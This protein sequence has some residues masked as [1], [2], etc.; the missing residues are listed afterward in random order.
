MKA[1]RFFLI[2]L[3][4]GMTL[5]GCGNRVVVSG[6]QAIKLDYDVHAS[7]WQLNDGYYS[8]TLDVSD[9]TPS[10]VK[11]GKV[12]V[13]RRYPGE[14]EGG[15]DVWTPLPCMQTNVEDVDGTSVYFT[16]F[17]DYEWMERTVN[18]FVTAS[19]LYTGHV[20]PTMHF[21]VFVTK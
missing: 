13:A 5:T 12:D 19:D 16:T 17:V 21:R 15:S 8:A 6:Q 14:G 18:V 9:I 20:P 2:L 11:H 3:A 7:Q 4:A 10:V 1:K